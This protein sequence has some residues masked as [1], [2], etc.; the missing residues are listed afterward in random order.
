MT[1][2]VKGFTMNTNKEKCREKE[3]GKLSKR[4]F[5]SGEKED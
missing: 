5:I 1:N 4:S 3:K 2:S